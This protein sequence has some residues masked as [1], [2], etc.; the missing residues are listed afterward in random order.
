MGESGPHLLQFLEPRH[1]QLFHFAWRVNDHVHQYFR[2]YSKLLEHHVHS[3]CHC[4]RQS[5]QLRAGIANFSPV[6]WRLF[7]EGKREKLDRAVEDRHLCA[8]PLFGSWLSHVDIGFGVVELFCLVGIRVQ[9]LGIFWVGWGELEAWEFWSHALRLALKIR[10]AL[11]GEGS[12]CSM[13]AAW[14]TTSFKALFAACSFRDRRSHF[15]TSFW[16]TIYPI[17]CLRR[18]WRLSFGYS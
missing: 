17:S 7:G 16:V 8:K 11:F 1:V 3:F 15:P 9:F 14:S 13:I 5:E 18:S 4:L 12:W 2:S 6:E 10:I